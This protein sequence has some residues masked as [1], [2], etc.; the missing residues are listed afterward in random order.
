MTQTFQ[1]WIDSREAAEMLGQT[2][3]T[4]REW[5]K[6]GQ[7]RGVKMPGGRWRIKRSDVEALLDGEAQK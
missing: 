3:Y 2:S 1:V 4:T 6:A 7:L 5:L